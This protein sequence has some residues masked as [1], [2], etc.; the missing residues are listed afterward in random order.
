MIKNYLLD[1]NIVG[2]YFRD[3]YGIGSH[4]KSIG[5]FEHCA[6][7]EITLAELKYGTKKSRR[8]EQNRKMLS[9]FSDNIVLTRAANDGHIPMSIAQ[10]EASPPVSYDG[11]SFAN[12]DEYLKQIP[13]FLNT[14]DKEAQSSVRYSRSEIGL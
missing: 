11:D 3:K 12:D 5:G 13:G 6:I 1:T 14:L 8:K 2:F 10:A 7:S 9:E 4:I